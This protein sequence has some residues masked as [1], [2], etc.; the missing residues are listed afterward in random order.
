MTTKITVAS[1]QQEHSY[2]FATDDWIAPFNAARHNRQVKRVMLG[3]GGLRELQRMRTTMNHIRTCAKWDAR[4][5]AMRGR[6]TSDAELMKFPPAY[7][8]SY[9]RAWRS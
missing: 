4:D 2:D 1:G 8:R 5:D 6:K 7:R 9:L 3:T